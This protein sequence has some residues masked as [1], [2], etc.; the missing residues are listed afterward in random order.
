MTI[1]ELIQNLEMCDEDVK[2]YDV[3]VVFRIQLNKNVR[4]SGQAFTLVVPD[5]VDVNNAIMWLKAR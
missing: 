2:D 1:R 4:I 5:S 3:G